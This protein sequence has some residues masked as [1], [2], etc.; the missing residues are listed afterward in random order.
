VLLGYWMGRNSI[1]RPM[2]SVNNPA[3][4]SQGPSVDDM[5]EDVFIAAMTEPDDN[6]RP[7]LGVRQ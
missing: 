6:R 3:A 7:T 2:R 5:S 4:N 1:E